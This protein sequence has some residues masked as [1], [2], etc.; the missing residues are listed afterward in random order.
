M[1][2]RIQCSFNLRRARILVPAEQR[3]DARTLGTKIK[4]FYEESNAADRIRGEGQRDFRDR[5]LIDLVSTSG[6]ITQGVIYAWEEG[7]PARELHIPRNGQQVWI[8][9]AEANRQEGDKCA[10][11]ERGMVF[12]AIKGDYVAYCTRKTGVKLFTETVED[13]LRKMLRCTVSVTLDPLPALDLR[14]EILSDNV[15]CVSLCSGIQ[16]ESSQHGIWK[17]GLKTLQAFGGLLGDSSQHFEEDISDELVVKVTF[18]P[19]DKRHLSGGSRRVLAQIARRLGDF[20]NMRIRLRDGR[21]LTQEQLRINGTK[22]IEGSNHLPQ[23]DTLLRQLSF[24]LENH[25][26][27]NADV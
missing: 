16:T 19:K 22:Y 1:P 17:F 24:W 8:G 6:G 11:W 10:E 7:V 4:E 27:P 15:E 9:N 2:E 13:A 14:D 12:F 23:V 26:P 25:L 20:P 3:F 5:Q 21:E 18:K